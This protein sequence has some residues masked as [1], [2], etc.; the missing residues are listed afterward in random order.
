MYLEVELALAGGGGIGHA[1][2]DDPHGHRVDINDLEAVDSAAGARHLE[3]HV[4]TLGVRL[5]SM[6]HGL[7]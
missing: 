3:G 6:F 4:G 1:L 2:F 5:K 7:E